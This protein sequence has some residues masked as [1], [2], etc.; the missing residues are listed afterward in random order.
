MLQHTGWNTLVYPQTAHFHK[1][2][3]PFDDLSPSFAPTDEFAILCGSE[4]PGYFID[5]TGQV[6]G[7]NGPPFESF[8]ALSLCMG[9]VW[10]V[11]LPCRMYVVFVGIALIA[12]LSHLYYFFKIIFIMCTG[13]ASTESPL[14]LRE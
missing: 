2:R 12:I 8:N 10:S 5:I 1:K 3:Q 14:S 9:L 11:T 4:R 6:T 7:E 13:A